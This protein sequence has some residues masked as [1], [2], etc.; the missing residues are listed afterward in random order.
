MKL[1]Q[2]A[3]HLLEKA[4]HH[5]KLERKYTEERLTLENADKW[6]DAR[7][8]RDDEHVQFGKMDAYSEML[9]KELN[10]SWNNALAMA[11]RYANWDG[12]E[13]RVS[14][15]TLDTDRDHSGDT[16]GHVQLFHLDGTTTT[17]DIFNSPEDKEYYF[18]VEGEEDEEY[19]DYLLSD[20]TSYR[21]ED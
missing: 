2:T 5:F 8:K 1:S 12:M 19:D 14:Q 4:S 10:I 15:W 9:A 18:C 16:V 20:F 7:H 21:A 3:Q 11:Q 6:E 17:H 13:W